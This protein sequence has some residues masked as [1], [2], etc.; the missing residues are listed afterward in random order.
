[1]CSTV[2]VPPVAARATLLI[3]ILALSSW[4]SPLNRTVM[5]TAV[6]SVSYIVAPH[7]TVKPHDIPAAAHQPWMCNGSTENSVVLFVLW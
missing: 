2:F 4:L 7:R 1:M 5:C 6:P 3:S